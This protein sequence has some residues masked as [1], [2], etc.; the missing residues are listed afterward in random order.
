M[1]RD[2]KI[3]ALLLVFA[4]VT[5]CP[6]PAAPPAPPAEVPAALRF[7]ESIAINVDKVATQP[8]S[9]SPGALK[10]FVGAGGEFSKE[11]AFGA[12]FA[13]VTTDFID[14]ILKFLNQ[15]EIPVD[16][17]VTTF[18]GE[19]TLDAS[20]TGTVK[21]DFADFDLDGDG[22]TE[23]CSGNTAGLPICF[24]VWTN[25]TRTLAGFFTAFPTDENQ[26]AGRLRI[27]LSSEGFNQGGAAIYDHK[28]PLK[29][30]SESFFIFASGSLGADGRPQVLLTTH[31]IANQVGLDETAN[32]TLQTSVEDRGLVEAF[33]GDVI[34]ASDDINTLKYVGRWR[35][36]NDFWS[37]SLQTTFSQLSNF[38]AICARISTGDESVEA[39]C[40]D[41]SIDVTNLPFVTF[42]K[43]SD[44]G[45]P[46]VDAFPESPTF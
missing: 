9:P 41:L 16:T 11:I 14:S 13:K 46:S 26:G 32:K 44:V 12:D 42:A 23:G 1:M 29:K 33:A 37:G 5:S 7:P 20:T 4:A 18:Q 30:T 45:F 31:T 15:F 39:N 35:E 19:G 28:D 38:S 24:R 22:K 25:D 3:A 2:F 10:A 21:I 8:P 27:G 36:D 43:D 6:N 40:R 17:A 34:H